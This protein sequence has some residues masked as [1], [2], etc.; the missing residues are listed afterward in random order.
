MNKIKIKS[1][2]KIMTRGL[3]MDSSPVFSGQERNFVS[4]NSLP[5][6][7]VDVCHLPIMALG[8][9]TCIICNGQKHD[10]INTA[11]LPV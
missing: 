8:N 11:G 3:P 9:D 10:Q 4:G 2:I 1:K 6:G 5:Q 7:E